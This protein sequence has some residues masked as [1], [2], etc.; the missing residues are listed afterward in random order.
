MTDAVLQTFQQR[1]NKQP[2]LIRAP[3]RINLM[4]EH[5]DYNKGFV[6]PAAIDKAVTLAVSVSGT[7][8]CEIAALDVNEH[9]QFSVHDLHPS[10]DWATYIKGVVS[11]FTRL[12]FNPSGIQAVFSSSIP[13]GAGLSSSA[14][15]CSGFAFVINDLFSFGLDRLSLARIAQQ[16]EH[17]FAGVKCGIMDQYA[18]LFGKRDSVLLLDCQTATHTYF[19]LSLTDHSLLLIDTK[20]KHSLASSAYNERRHSCEEGVQ[21]LQQRHPHIKSLRDVTADMLWAHKSLLS[22]ETYQRCRFVVEEIARTQHAAQLLQQ[23]NLPAFGACMYETHEG[24]SAHYEVSC[25]EADFLVD[26]A[27]QNGVTGARMMGGGFGGCTLN[28]LKSV[29]LPDL[30]KIMAE[31]YN[32]AFGVTPAFYDVRIEKGVHAIA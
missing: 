21:Q 17:N 4:G 10:N 20:V 11:G 18:S 16:S 12:G 15:L 9:R 5:T 26:I 27:R 8:T 14:A 28:L 24:L 7:D 29:M 3:G 30:K 22:G 1:F 6:M 31:K 19:P 23:G 25:A 2:L 32:A 13:I